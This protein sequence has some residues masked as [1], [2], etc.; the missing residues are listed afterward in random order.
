MSKLSLAHACIN[1]TSLEQTASFY[2]DA[3]GLE[4]HFDFTRA[5]KPGGFYLKAANGAFIEVFLVAE[6][7]I[8]GAR[9]LNHF[10][11]ETGD[12]KGLR[13]RLVDHGYQPGEIKMGADQTW[14]FWINDPNGLPVEFQEYTAQSAQHTGKTVEINW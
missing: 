5:G 3:L 7:E 4:R 2:C 11:L 12:L 6:T 14:Q 10:C 13:Q 9:I 1:T 8:T